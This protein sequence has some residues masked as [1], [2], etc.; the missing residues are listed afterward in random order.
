MS[1]RR[2]LLRVGR[3]GGLGLLEVIERFLL[4]PVGERLVAG[5]ELLAGLA[6]ILPLGLRLLVLGEELL[7]DL[8]RGLSPRRHGQRER[9]AD[10]GGAEDVSHRVLLL[11]LV[12]G[13]LAGGDR[14]RKGSEL[15]SGLGQVAVPAPEEEERTPLARLGVLDPADVDDVVAA[16]ERV[17]DA[18][19][20]VPER[21]REDGRAEPAEPEL[22]AGELLP[23]RGGKAPRDRLLLLGE[24]VEH[25]D[26]RVEEVRVSLGLAVDAD[27]E[28]RGGERERGDRVGREPVGLPA[29][30]ARGD[31][32]DAGR[33]AAHHLAQLVRLD[34][35]PD[36]LMP[37]GRTCQRRPGLPPAD[38]G[39]NELAV[40]M[41]ID[42]DGH[43]LEPPDL[44]ERCLE[45]AYR[46]RAIRVRRGGDG[47]DFLEVDGRPARLTTPEMLGGLGGMGKSLEELAAAC[48]AGRYAESAPPAATDPAAR[49]ALLDHDGIARALLYPSLGL[50]WEAEVPDPG[51][52]LAHARAYNRWIEEFSAGSGGRLG[53][54]APL[55]LGDPEDAARGVWRAVRP[56]ARGGSP[57]PFIQCRGR[58]GHPVHDPLWAGAE[59]L[60][61]PIAIHTG[62]DPTARDL[63][64]RFDGLAWP[65]GVVQG[66]WYLQLM[67]AKA[68][69]QAFST[70]FLHATFDRFPR[71]N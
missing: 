53:P 7:L 33:E 49:L 19:L 69:Q 42:A 60:D 41:V 39:G 43:V 35:H 47:R 10:G 18:A 24:D 64:H 17:D 61:V 3:P 11:V 16:L 14:P 67:F 46:A 52:A 21:A 32:G 36:G 62:V 48:L 20:D 34:R 68:V 25:E 4:E 27:Q 71:L 5:V 56:G 38:A 28:E 6:E 9:E 12:S 50:Q 54:I 51:Y 59:E 15:A 44:W 55:P 26:L 22:Q 45:P 40:E 63:H 57:L 70:F 30:V 66:I 2:Y 31:D 23:A 29:L 1:T 65:E 8:G 58:H 37:A 13:S